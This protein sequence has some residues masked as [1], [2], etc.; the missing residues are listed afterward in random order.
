MPLETQHTL[1]RRP[2]CPNPTTLVR[3][4]TLVRKNYNPAHPNPSTWCP[5]PTTLVRKKLKPS[6]P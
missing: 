3:P 2:W 4:P 5:N 6:T 1:I